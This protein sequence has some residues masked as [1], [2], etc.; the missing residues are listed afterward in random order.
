[1]S[2]SAG[3]KP[4]P[5]QVVLID[6]HFL[7]G[8]KKKK[9]EQV[10]RNT[11][12]PEDEKGITELGEIARSRDPVD[13]K[14]GRCMLI[15]YTLHQDK[16]LAVASAIELTK[17]YNQADQ[18]GREA[19]Y[20]ECCNAIRGYEGVHVN[21]KNYLVYTDRL[22]E[23]IRRLPIS[24]GKKRETGKLIAGL[25][26]GK[27]LKKS[28]SL[29]LKGDRAAVEK[30]VRCA[31]SD[32][33]LVR[34]D[35]T[36]MMFQLCKF[37]QAMKNVKDAAT[38]YLLTEGGFPESRN[39]VQTDSVRPREFNTSN[40]H[41]GGIAHVV[42]VFAD[43]T[44][45]KL[46]DGEKNTVQQLRYNVAKDA[47]DKAN[48]IIN[49]AQDS[50][51]AAISQSPQDV[52][53][54][55]SAAETSAHAEKKLNA[56]VTA[57]L[58]NL[59]NNDDNKLVENLK[60]FAKSA[61]TFA[62]ED[63]HIA[64]DIL[65]N[66][67]CH[68]NADVRQ[69]AITGIK[70]LPTEWAKPIGDSVS[71]YMK[72][73]KATLKKIS[74]VVQD[75]QLDPLY[76]AFT[77]LAQLYASSAATAPGGKVVVGGESKYVPNGGLFIA[78][79]AAAAASSA[80]DWNQ[81]LIHPH[82]DDSQDVT[83]KTDTGVGGT[84]GTKDPQRIAEELQEKNKENDQGAILMDQQKIDEKSIEPEIEPEKDLL[85][86]PED[87]LAL[88][89]SIPEV[90]SESVFSLPRIESGANEPGPD[91]EKAPNEKEIKASP[92]SVV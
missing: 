66:Y 19:I 45:Q 49:G 15:N 73:E 33:D 8:S 67:V 51:T 61:Q 59:G 42:K 58:A 86:V 10:R 88:E 28:Y 40:P 82:G 78:E 24:D 90:G 29:A 3:T 36:R 25:A 50:A 44:I 57:Y 72:L 52:D 75:D 71:G 38:C 89:E 46:G 37:P 34:S 39:V 77:D 1:M 27:N 84:E 70:A 68:S 12:S 63:D 87:N 85:A 79:D 65:M 56:T 81:E 6:R 21:D 53:A 5:L 2:V 35:A 4:K 20:S 11:L 91:S 80:P 16:P 13:A 22:K 14:A 64:L 48:F 32:I 83:D 41:L 31:A 30:I 43:K 47:L 18:Y 62:A 7:L 54:P 23:F 17:S 69:A 76:Q 74:G 60:N 9:P 55:A 92:E 26:D